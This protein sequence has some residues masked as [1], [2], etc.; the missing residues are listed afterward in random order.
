GASMRWSGP[1]MLTALGGV[2][3]AAVLAVLVVR[4][5]SAPFRE[6][7]SL[8]TPPQPESDA[9][10]QEAKPTAALGK[11]ES[12]SAT[13]PGAAGG[14]TRPGDKALRK[15][16]PEKEKLRALGYVQGSDEERGPR[17]QQRPSPGLL[18]GATRKRSAGGAPAAKRDFA[19][20][21]Y[22]P[23]PPRHAPATP[24]PAMPPH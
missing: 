21:G 5:G 12:P 17:A 14:T 1:R 6:G 23:A 22:A 3:A 13:A 18:D 11:D 10:R 24:P 15:G 9:M 7:S 16:T 2:A 20:H 8:S 4:E 19:E